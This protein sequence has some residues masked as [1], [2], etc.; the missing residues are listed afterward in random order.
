MARPT[1]TISRSFLAA[2]SAMERIRPRFEAKM[3]TATRFFARATTSERPWAT[4]PSD[5]LRPARTALVE[6]QIMAST[7]SA[8]ISARRFMSIGRPTR[9]SWSIFQSP[10]CSTLPIGVRINTAVG[11]GNECDMAISSRSKGPMEKRCPC[12]TTLVGTRG[13][14]GSISRFAACRAAAKGVM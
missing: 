7:P 13:A 11:S 9:G 2:A 14:L 4:S 10:V 12:S 5:G 6:S 8:L 3:V 1:T